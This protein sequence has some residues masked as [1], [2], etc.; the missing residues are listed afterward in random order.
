MIPLTNLF[1]YWT[2]Q[3]FSPGTVLREKYEAFK[4][5]LR[6]D[7]KAH[8]LM[9]ELEEIYH[10]HIK[11]DFSVIEKKCSELSRSV[12]N[13]VEDLNRMHPTTYSNLRDYYRKLDFY[14][15]F[16][17]TP[18]EYDFSPPFAIPLKKI[19][20]DDLLLV[21]G[22]A[23]NLAIIESALQ[24]PIPKG[25]AIT[26]NAFYYFIEFND[27]RKRIDK[28]LSR[29][30]IN[31]PVSIDAVSDELMTIILNALIPPDIEKAI[32]DSF[33]QLQREPAGM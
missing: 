23:L 10:D 27:L 4:S 22:K 6:N 30:D 18:R 28:G 17:L 11:V 7:K 19:S 1:K 32:I 2:Y 25:F 24:L 21:G 20:P 31:S 29:L 5:L 33:S 13:I 15:R 12:S 16:M 26:T 14:I 9:A 3:V 8:E